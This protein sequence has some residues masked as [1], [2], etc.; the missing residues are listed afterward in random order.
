[1][2]KTG[3]IFRPVV[4]TAEQPFVTIPN[5]WPEICTELALCSGAVGVLVFA[6]EEGAPIFMGTT[7][8]HDTTEIGMPAPTPELNPIQSFYGHTANWWVRQMLPP[9]FTCRG[10]LEETEHTLDHGHLF[11]IIL[12]YL[13]LTFNC[14][15][16]Q[17]TT[18][19]T[20]SLPTTNLRLCEKDSVVYGA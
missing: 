19:V 10:Q 12:V 9:T 6:V 18:C 16:K 2:L 17:D 3:I 5:N 13:Q 1:M 11:L 14:S 7:P 20:V 15:Q 4:D 8:E